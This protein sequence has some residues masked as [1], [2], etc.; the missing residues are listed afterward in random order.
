MSTPN[1]V[2]IGHVV[3]QVTDLSASRAFY[4]GLLGLDVVDES[5]TYVCLRGVEEREWS[6]ML[7]ERPEPAVRQI[8]FKVAAEEELDALT[9]MA[10][11]SGLSCERRTEPGRPSMV[12]VEDPFGLPLAF[13]FASDKRPWLLQQYHQRRCPTVQRIDHVN[14]FTSTPGAMLT[15]YRDALGFRLTEYTQ[16]DDGHIWAAWLHRKGNVHDLACTNGDGPRLHHLAFWMPDAAQVLELCDILGAARSG[17]IERGPGR[18]GIS[19]A[20][21]LYLRDPD[22][23][24]VEIYTSDYLTVD[25]DFEPVR[26][27]RDDP[28]RQQLWGGL[29]PKSWFTEGS[30]VRRPDGTLHPVAPP[31]LEGLPTYIS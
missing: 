8:G 1:V 30:L 21:F 27:R 24:R 12:A 26:W 19:N 3:L 7:E 10:R 23:H 4:V 13:Y 9:R 18:H 17:A 5:P 16:D 22:G 14:V 28:Y 29:A 31:L 6:L 2:R 11:Q 15:W 20:L 25:P